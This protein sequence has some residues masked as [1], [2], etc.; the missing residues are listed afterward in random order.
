MK[1]ALEDC[2]R[3]PVLNNGSASINKICATAL[4]NLKCKE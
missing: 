4:D 3:H 2:R 1:S